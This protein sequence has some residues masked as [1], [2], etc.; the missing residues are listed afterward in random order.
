[1][2]TF[3]TKFCNE[4]KK[5]KPKLLLQSYFLGKIKKI[6]SLNNETTILRFA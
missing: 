2:R 6:T 4:P 5:R 3:Y 1:M